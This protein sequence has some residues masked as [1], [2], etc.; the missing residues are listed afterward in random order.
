[1]HVRGDWGSSRVWPRSGLVLRCLGPGFTVLA[2][3]LGE[4]PITVYR[5]MSYIIF[6]FKRSIPLT[7]AGTGGFNGHVK[8]EKYDASPAPARSHHPPLPRM[9]LSRSPL[10]L[11]PPSRLPLLRLLISTPVQVWGP[12]LPLPS[13]L[14]T[15][16]I[17]LCAV[18]IVVRRGAHG[19][20]YLPATLSLLHVWGWLVSRR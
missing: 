6:H 20:A 1:M 18:Y 5:Y 8:S 10:H 15:P 4:Q 16:S 2:Q 11:A 14:H 17:G 3:V 13:P 12:G 7:A 9:P 19:R